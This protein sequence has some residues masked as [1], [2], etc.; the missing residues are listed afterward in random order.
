MS[1]PVVRLDLDLRQ[2]AGQ[3]LRVRQ[4]CCP[5][6]SR[7]VVQL[8]IWTPG[9]YTVRD[10]VQHLHSLVAHCGDDPIS[11][12]RIGLS[13]WLVEMPRREVL[14]LDYAIEARD[15]TVRTC[16]LDPDFAS[17]SLA[18]VAMDVEGCRWHEHRL[19]V[20]VPEAW[21]VHVPLP[22]VD[23]AWIAEDFDGL[24][25]SPVHAGSF[26]VERFDVDGHGH[27]LLLIGS[28]PGGWPSS[29]TQDIT[30]VCRA[31]C[32]LMDTP[33]P[34]GDRY[35]LV[36]QMLESGYGGLEHDHSAVLQF[37]WPA[38]ARPG[39]LRQLLQ[40][41]GHEY[42]HQW[43][44]RRLRPAD[45]RPYDYGR[46]VVSEGLWFAEGI[47]SYFDLSTT[48]LSGFSNRTQFLQDLGEELS[49][50]LMTPGRSV[51]SLADS[52]REAWVKLYKATPSSRDS[53][54]SYYRYGAATAFCLDVR[55]RQVGSSLSTVLREL[56]ASH[57]RCGRGYQRQNILSAIAK[58]DSSLAAQ[59]DGWLDEPD[60]LPLE[61]LVAA[62]GLRLDPIQSSEP[63]H[64]LNLE[65]QAS[66]VVVKRVAPRG[67]AMQAGLVVGDELIA[68]GGRR[69]RRMADLPMLLKGQSRVPVLWS[70]RGLMKESLLIPDECIDRWTLRWDP[71]ATA[72]QLAL[73]DRWFQIL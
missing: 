71:G 46:P 21:S 62:L 63:H 56:W 45:Y 59:L 50:V 1:S 23:Q 29:L 41:V 47:T 43:N 51:Q 72:E 20:A 2:P 53:Q 54:V 17:L 58:R 61:A 67:P 55:L 73:R 60:S 27:E 12:R 70:R 5:E 38:F 31:T 25:D 9:S 30:S 28:P 26:D 24:V 22:F 66:G 57:G 64:G 40:L 19:T 52:A 69:L 37:N 68:I 35:Q 42:L 36:I 13:R 15:L 3:T 8:P 39:G 18:A 49:R 32:R 16:H 34:A 44:V 14:T 48:L 7:V 6:A 65:D 10:H 11:A 33:P 4:T